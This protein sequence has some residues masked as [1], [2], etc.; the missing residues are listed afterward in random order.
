M[1]YLQR[2]NLLAAHWYDKHD[3]FVMS[4]IYNT[5]SV[6]IQHHGDKDLVQKPTLIDQYNTFM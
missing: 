3:V 4:N 6:E 5:G 2:K 1:I